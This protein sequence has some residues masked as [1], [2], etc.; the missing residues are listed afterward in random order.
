MKKETYAKRIADA[1]K[2]D[3]GV[4]KTP[5]SSAGFIY[6]LFKTYNSIGS[7]DDFTASVEYSKGRSIS[8][9]AGEPNL[10][11]IED[12]PVSHKGEYRMPYFRYGRGYY[13]LN[14]STINSSVLK[15][16][17]ANEDQ[18]ADYV[19]DRRL[20]INHM[21]IGY[22]CN[23]RTYEDVPYEPL[24]QAEIAENLEMI[25]TRLNRLHGMFVH[26]CNLEGYRISALDIPKY[27]EAFSKVLGMSPEYNFSVEEFSGAVAI[28]KP[29]KKAD[30]VEFVNN[31]SGFNGRVDY[32]EFINLT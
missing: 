26:A 11:F 8:Y 18:L 15:F 13:T 5:K 4:N 32:T 23:N 3:A 27:E 12:T 6:N 21:V 7:G 30:V 22:G 2:C 31:Q 9:K 1:L 14:C 10:L 29:R 24:Y 19:S 20:Q 17:L 28:M 25:S 16:L